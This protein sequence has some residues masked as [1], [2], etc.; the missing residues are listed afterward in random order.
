SS[1]L[2][3]IDDCPKKAPVC[4]KSYK[5]APPLLLIS[6]DGFRPD[7]LKRGLNPTL[8][9]L[10]RCGVRTPYMMPVFPTKTFPNHYSQVTGLYPSSHGIIDNFMIDPKTE[11]QFKIGTNSSVESF[12][13]EK[14][15]IWVSAEKQG[16]KSATFFWPGSDVEINGTRPTYYKE[17]NGSIPFEERVDQVLEWLDLSPS[18]RP[19]F[20]TLYISEVDSSAHAYGIHSQ[21]VNE[22]LSRADLVIERLFTGLQKR[23]LIDC[24]NVFIMSDHGMADTD[25][26]RSVDLGEY[27]DLACVRSTEGA[28]GRLQLKNCPNTTLEQLEE[29]IRCRI[30]HTRVYRKEMLPVRAHYAN[31][32]RIEPIFLDL[33]SGWTLLRKEPGKREYRCNGGN[34]GYDNLFPDMKA[35]F[36]A[37]GPSMKRNFTVEPFINTELYEL[38]CE[39]IGITPN[40]NN[41]TRGSLHHLLKKLIRP[42]QEEEEPNPPAKGV[43]KEH[44][45]TAAQ[46]PCKWPT[47]LKVNNTRVQVLHLP[48]GVPF[49]AQGNKSLL[50][51]HNVDYME[52][53]NTALRTAEWVGFALDAKNQSSNRTSLDE[54]ICWTD[55]ARVPSNDTIKCSDYNF[56]HVG[57]EL[58]SQRP[59]Y[60]P[61]MSSSS[62][63]TNSTFVTNSVTKSSHHLPLE[64]ALMEFFDQWT[65]KG[66]ALHVLTGPAFD[67]LGT[68]HR[69][70]FEALQQRNGSLLIP[71]HLFY[72]ITWCRDDV[73]HIGDCNPDDLKVCSFLLPNWPFPDNCQSAEKDIKKNVARV[74]DIE[75]LT[76]L[77]LYLALPNAKWQ[78]TVEHQMKTSH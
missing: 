77:S 60:H 65:S 19:S 17:Y 45:S 34:H 74:V 21:Q 7:Y 59:F 48:F 2:E 31:H 30:N 6:L 41:G 14:E 27:V 51:L 71:T 54:E 38:M 18:E 23:N 61:D 52:A 66:K 39:M 62:N 5:G 22:S 46:C 15:P 67:F 8:E 49:S 24:I 20:L 29:A 56:T 50:L 1:S 40:P 32:P 55:D 33:D 47:D 53:Y 4:P 12:W 57:E 36:M 37:V 64:E 73:K 72:V 58:F 42:L 11:K 3:W 9:R 26:S 70:D 63:G 25:C 43:A 68:G 35:F 28:V 75:E 16:K 13:W 10:S 78:Q 76:G 44:E 69:P